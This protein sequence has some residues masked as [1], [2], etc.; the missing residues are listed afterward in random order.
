MVRR[1]IPGSDGFAGISQL[2]VLVFPAKLKHRSLV[3]HPEL[4][5]SADRS[6]ID[7]ET[8]A[9][10]R[11]VS[12]T[13]IVFEKNAIPFDELYAA[14]THDLPIRVFDIPFPYPKIELA[15][16]RIG[17]AGGGGWGSSLTEQGTPNKKGNEKKGYSLHH[18]SPN[19]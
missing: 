12:H 6:I 1:L 11:W 9:G 7:I 15:V 8:F 19:W 4:L 13:R 14:P 5:P 18:F 17:F 2:T 3:I 10:V 16:R